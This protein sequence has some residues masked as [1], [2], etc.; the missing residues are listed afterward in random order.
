MDQVVGNASKSHEN[1]KSETNRS[2]VLS[3]YPPAGN[4]KNREL[5][6]DIEE[7][8]R[9]QSIADMIKTAEAS[10]GT[11][12]SREDL[13]GLRLGGFGG[14]DDIHGEIRNI[15]VQ[16][17]GDENDKFRLNL[18]QIKDNDELTPFQKHIIE[19]IKT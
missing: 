7:A 14:I 4:R 15:L 8:K 18:Q 9:E 13:D 10:C 2:N 1:E 11:A 5:L 6:T 12:L 3:K 19:K 16:Q 17:H